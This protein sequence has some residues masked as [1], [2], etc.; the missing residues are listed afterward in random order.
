[1]GVVETI[2]REALFGGQFLFF[3]GELDGEDVVS[4]RVEATEMN[5][6]GLEKLFD[7]GDGP[8]RMDSSLESVLASLMLQLEMA[9]FIA[10]SFCCCRAFLRSGWWGVMGDR[11]GV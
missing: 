8:G 9:L 2:R 3:G 6:F 10:G 4:A 5:V 7:A 11:G 1:M